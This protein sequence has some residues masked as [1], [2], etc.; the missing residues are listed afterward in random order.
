MTI[1]DDGL[2]FD[3]AETAKNRY[4]LIGMN[5]RVSLLGGQLHIETGLGAGT[6]LIVAVPHLRQ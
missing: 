5:E 3:P 2:G 1:Q 6:R 4:G